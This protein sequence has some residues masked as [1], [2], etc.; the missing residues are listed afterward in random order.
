MAKTDKIKTKTNKKTNNGKN[1]NRK[2]AGSSVPSVLRAVKE[3]RISP[4]I[5][6]A[7]LIL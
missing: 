2:M 7:L 6:A 3:G 1:N 5:A 4:T